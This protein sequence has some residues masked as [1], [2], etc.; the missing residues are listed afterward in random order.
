MGINY[1][2]LLSLNALSDL[3]IEE[4]KMKKDCILDLDSRDL[5]HWGKER[6]LISFKES[7]V[8]YTATIYYGAYGISQIRRKI[9]MLLLSS[10][11]RVDSL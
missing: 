4:C 7:Q 8:L 9:Q 11:F 6:G 2:D 3:Y 5:I 1:D 10:F